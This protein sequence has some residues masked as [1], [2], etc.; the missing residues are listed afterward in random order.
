MYLVKS[1]AVKSEKFVPTGFQAINIFSS[2]LG[3]F[4]GG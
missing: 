4:Y 3:Y 2:D 1:F